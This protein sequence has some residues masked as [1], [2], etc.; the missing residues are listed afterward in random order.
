[1]KIAFYT[2]GCKSNQFDEAMMKQKLEKEGVDFVPFN[3]LADIYIINTCTVTG[4]TDYQSRQAIRNAVRKIQNSK[5]KTQ[6]SK[7]IV[8]GCYAQVNQE[9][10]KAIP[11]V[12]LVIGNQEKERIEKYISELPQNRK[13]IF[14]VGDI[15]NAQRFNF[16]EIKSFWNRTRAFVKIQ[17]G[18]N[19]RC[20]YCIVPYARGQNRSLEMEKV[21]EQVEEL[22]KRGYNEVVLTGV[23]LG[24]YGE[25][26]SDGTNLTFLLQRLEEIKENFR[27]RLSSIEPL[28]ISDEL[29]DTIA[30]SKKICPHLHIPLQSG[31]DEILKK[32]NRNYTTILFKELLD[33][34]I[35]IIPKLNIGTDVIVGFPGET[36]EQFQKTYEFVKGLPFGYLH[37]FPYS[38]RPATPAASFQEQVSSLH[39][40]ERSS[41]LRDLGEKKKIEFR[42]KFIGKRLSVL[43]EGK[44]DKETGLYRGF[45]E[46]YIPVVFDGR[47]ELKNKILSV[48]LTKIEGNKVYGELNPQSEI[49]NH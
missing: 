41:F 38:R 39:I 16:V 48:K 32:M 46:N 6:N 23:H 33:K 40:K 9:A 30:T 4:K 25:D 7:V 20:S 47:E 44:R 19:S 1:M 18:C 22:I 49:C 27:I 3:S 8:T 28:E 31:D 36:E 45:S 17:D 21:K 12:S 35:R 14:Q 29:I 11:G 5:L 15:L 24:T 37:V 43:V 13:V 10:I 26:F 42:T 2:L 34:L